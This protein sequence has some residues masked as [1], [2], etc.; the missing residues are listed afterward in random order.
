MKLLFLKFSC[1]IFKHGFL[2]LGSF[3]LYDLHTVGD[4][5]GGAYLIFTLPN[6]HV[7]YCW[8]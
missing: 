6:E 7:C 4:F 1:A 8:R 5:H 2:L 3:L